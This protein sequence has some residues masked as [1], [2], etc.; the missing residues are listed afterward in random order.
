MTNQIANLPA[1]IFQDIDQ[2]MVSVVLYGTDPNDQFQGRYEAVMSSAIR[3]QQDV[4]HV[5]A[6]ASAAGWQNFRVQRY[7]LRG[8]SAKDVIAAFGAAVT[9]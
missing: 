1:S 9:I 6:Q 4:D 7:D 8:G 2:P 3:S 5:I